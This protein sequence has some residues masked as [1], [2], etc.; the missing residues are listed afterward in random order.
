MVNDKKTS[1]R[2]TSNDTSSI[3]F[4]RGHQTGKISLV[5][6]TDNAPGSEF[7]SMIHHYQHT[8]LTPFDCKTRASKDFNVSTIVLSPFIKTR[9]RLG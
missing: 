1:N 9:L 4:L 8:S 5:Q 7:P 2:D 6:I 3:L